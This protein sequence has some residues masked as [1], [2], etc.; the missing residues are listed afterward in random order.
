MYQ[1]EHIRLRAFESD[2]LA[3]SHDFMNDYATMRGA[4]SGMLYPSS[5]EDEGRYLNGQSSYTHGEYQFAIETLDQTLI[6]RCGFTRVDWKNRYAELGILIGDSRF[7]GI[8][9]G[10]EAVR[11]L[12]D[13]GFNELNL[14]KIKA[15]VI[16]FNLSAIR[17]YE[18]CGFTREGTLRQEIWREGA[19]HG[20]VL[21]SLL[22]DEK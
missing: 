4:F 2:D 15:S 20:V 7:R 1:S 18:K 10:T 16:D 3:R 13:F 14:H 5:M 17:C 19:Y 21:L 9:Y 8:G 22:K 6:G 11:L 12:C